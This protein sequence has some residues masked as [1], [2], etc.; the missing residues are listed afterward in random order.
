MYKTGGG[1]NNN[2]VS[3]TTEKIIGLLGDQINPLFNSAD[4]D[5][6]YNDCKYQQY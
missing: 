2:H 5:A 1:S 6:N 3:K 4:S